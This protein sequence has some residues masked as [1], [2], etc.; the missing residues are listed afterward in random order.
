MNNNLNPDSILD[1]ITRSIFSDDDIASYL[2]HVCSISSLY[3]ST[4]DNA[5]HIAATCGR[6]E[7]MKWLIISK[8]IDVN[9]Q[10][11]VIPD[12]ADDLRLLPENK[13]ALMKS[14]FYGYINCAVCLMKLGATL[15][16]MNFRFLNTSKANQD[17]ER[18]NISMDSYLRLSPEEIMLNEIFSLCDDTLS[19]RISHRGL[20]PFN[21]YSF[22]GVSQ[23]DSNSDESSDDGKKTSSNKCSNEENN[24]C[25]SEK[26]SGEVYVF[27]S[28]KNYTIGSKESKSPQL[29]KSF[30][31]NYPKLK[32][33]SIYLDKYHTVLITNNG[34]IFSS[35]HGRGGR[36]GHSNE[37]S[38]IDFK[39]METPKIPF[40]SASIGRDHSV[41]LSNRGEVYTCGLN[42]YYVLGLYP[43][44]KQVLQPKIVEML[45]RHRILG[46]KA[47]RFHTIV[48]TGKKIWSWG[49]NGGQLGHNRTG[50]KFFIAPQLVKL[51]FEDDVF[52]KCVGSSIAATALATSSG[53]IFLFH[54]YKNKKI[55]SG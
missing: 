25:D 14:L 30:H 53:D 54:E 49:L 2:N 28:N 4:G 46:V 44:P 39:E 15:H 33:T 42:K 32:V 29:L 17:F 18:S 38:S 34:K 7:L 35:G 43:P 47:A 24:I 52:I 10:G 3:N 40:K 51:K 16:P 21:Y 1:L 8:L 12:S 37:K 5:L 11:A 13:T 48:W 50:D 27:G 36:L 22:P 41:L 9:V 45:R 23:K 20:T 6:K 55:I 19:R 31:H 26:R